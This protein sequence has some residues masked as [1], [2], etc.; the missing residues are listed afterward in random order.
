MGE[1]FE[2]NFEVTFFETDIKENNGKAYID[3]INI[4]G[5]FCRKAKVT[6]EK[7]FLPIKWI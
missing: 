3:N 5:E 2:N 4:F 1:K 6:R 7:A